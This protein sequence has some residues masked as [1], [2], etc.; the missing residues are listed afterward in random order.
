VRTGMPPWRSAPDDV[1]TARRIRVVSRR[2]RRR[3][4]PRSC[5]AR[6]SQHFPVRLARGTPGFAYYGPRTHLA[7]GLLRKNS[8]V[9]APKRKRK[10]ADAFN[11]DAA[12]D[13]LKALTEASVGSYAPPCFSLIG[14]T[15]QRPPFG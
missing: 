4:G 2:A 3:A 8:S 14:R 9:D 15:A 11:L 12:L 7:Q 13:D 10:R 5:G 1:H 6:E